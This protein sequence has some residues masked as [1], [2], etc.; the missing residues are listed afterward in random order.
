M[1]VSTSD[2][3]LSSSSVTVDVAP[4]GAVSVVGMGVSLSARAEAILGEE[5]ATLSDSGW[6]C[7]GGVALLVLVL[8]L[9]AS[10]KLLKRAA[11]A[12]GWTERWPGLGLALALALALALVLWLLRWSS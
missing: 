2:M 3:A 5:R 8:V 1:L 12:M 7:A 6:R 10:R 4:S 9:G 11:A